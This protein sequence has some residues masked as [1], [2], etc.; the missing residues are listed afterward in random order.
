MKK[1]IITLLIC[2]PLI[3]IAQTGRQK[4]SKDSVQYYQRQLR[5]LWKKSY[6]SMVNSEKYKEINQKLNSKGKNNSENF[7]VELTFFTGLQINNYS[8]LNARLTSLGVKEKKTLL[9]PLG[10]GLAFRFNKIIVGYDLT[11]I[12]VGD[13]SSGALGHGYLSTNVIKTKRWI[14]SPQVG[15]GGQSVTIRVPTQSPST[16]FNSYF[17]TSSNQ[18]EIRN[19]NT[20]L[21]F[22]LALKVYPKNR[23]TYIPVLRFGYRYGLTENAWEIRNGTSTNAPIDRNSNFYIHLMLGFGD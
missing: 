23:D 14:F 11:P 5:D 8:N 1:V 16:N 18:V 3:S 15:Y 10:I 2:C 22:A 13:N 12:L 19:K 7:G 4:L 20:F 6:D 9:L 21:D 17:T